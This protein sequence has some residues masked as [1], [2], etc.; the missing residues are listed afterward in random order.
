MEIEIKP[1]QI[2]AYVKKAILDSTVGKS[3]TENIEKGIKELMSGWNSPVK[4]FMNEQL[5][6]FTCEYMQQPEV[7]AACLEA[8]TRTITPEVMEAV[9]KYGVTELTRK[10]NDSK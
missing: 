1:E 8:I 7:K 5:K 10:Y 6:N 2:D 3:L 4:T 9:I